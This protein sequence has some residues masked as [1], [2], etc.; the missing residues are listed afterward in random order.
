M[1]VYFNYIQSRKMNRMKYTMK[2]RLVREEKGPPRSESGKVPQAVV[3]PS[4]V[5]KN[6]RKVHHFQPGTKALMEIRRFQ[7]STEQLVSKRSFLSGEGDF[8]EGKIMD[9]DTSQG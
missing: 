6:K 4:S 9:E 5:G 1:E 2:K 8:A 3:K 7:K